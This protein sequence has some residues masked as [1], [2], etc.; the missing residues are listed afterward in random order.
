MLDILKDILPYISGLYTLPWILV[1]FIVTTIIGKAVGRDKVDKVMNKIGLVLLYF[2]IPLL[3]FRIFLDLFEPGQVTFV[4]IVF[5]VLLL[6]YIIA[7]YY[8][9]YIASKNKLIDSKKDLFIKTMLTNQGRSSAFIGSAMMAYW[10]IE[11]GIMIALV[12]IALFAMIPYILSKMHE[13][14]SKKTKEEHI[15]V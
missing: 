3:V 9:R 2:F 10:P 4:I 12:G 15:K 8:A 6:M 11:A 1:G 7:Y 5:A 14:E 13:K